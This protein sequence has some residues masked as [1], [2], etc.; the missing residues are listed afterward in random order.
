[1]RK[2]LIALT[3]I[4]T[5][6]TLHADI[7][8]KQAVVVTQDGDLTEGQVV[9]VVSI[10]RKGAVYMVHRF[11]VLEIDRYHEYKF[12]WESREG[13]GVIHVPH[14]VLDIAGTEINREVE[15][16]YHFYRPQVWT[17]GIMTEE[18]N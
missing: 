3:L 14:N 11:C 15:E 7:Y 16:K 13:G 8:T 12:T 5:A 4:L 18:E 17:I 1:M 9:Y 6:S 2:F 10:E